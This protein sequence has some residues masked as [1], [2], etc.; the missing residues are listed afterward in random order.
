MEHLK[1]FLHGIYINRRWIVYT[2]FSIIYGIAPTY[3]SFP[4]W[5]GLSWFATPFVFGI[6][7]ALYLSGKNTL[8][9]EDNRYD[10]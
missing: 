8:L 4:L 3:F 5:F 9:S 6:V 1:Y 10:F 7:Y 2:P